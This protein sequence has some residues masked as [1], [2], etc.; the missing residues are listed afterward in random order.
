MMTL[1][2]AEKIANDP[3]RRY[4]LESRFIESWGTPTLAHHIMQQENWYTPEAIAKRQSGQCRGSSRWSAPTGIGIA[5]SAGIV[6]SVLGGLGA[7][8]ATFCLI[9]LSY[10]VWSGR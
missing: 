9:V 1:Q 10:I 7:G 8:F 5:I 3:N 4:R 2:E 6:V